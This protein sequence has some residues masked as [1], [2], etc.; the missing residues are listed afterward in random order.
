[1]YLLEEP[2]A[3]EKVVLGYI[4]SKDLDKLNKQKTFYFHSTN[5]Q[6]NLIGFPYDLYNASKLVIYSGGRTKPFYLTSYFGEIKS[7]Q[8]KHKSDIKGKENSTTEYYFEIQL[9]DTFKQDFRIENNTQIKTW[10]LDYKKEYEL[11][12]ID[13]LS[14]LTLSE[15]IF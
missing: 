3:K 13:Y 8:H 10:M 14:I 11:T 1:M 2:K 9:K 12:K 4:R 5:K 15:N 7:I 6:D